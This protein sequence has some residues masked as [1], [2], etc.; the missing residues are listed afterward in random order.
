MSSNTQCTYCTSAFKGLTI[1]RFFITWWEMMWQEQQ[2][3]L[4]R[5]RIHRVCALLFFKISFLFFNVLFP[6][7]LRNLIPLIVSASALDLIKFC[8]THPEFSIFTVSSIQGHASFTARIL[9]MESEFSLWHPR[10]VALLPVTF[11]TQ[12]CC[13]CLLKA[14]SSQTWAYTQLLQS[15]EHTA[16]IRLPPTSV[17]NFINFCVHKYTPTF[18]F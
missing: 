5:L 1:M 4:K 6:R 14:Y 8:L 12:W 9:L 16:A 3:F 2:N 13:L 17:V 11:G 10:F 15:A 18:I 7:C